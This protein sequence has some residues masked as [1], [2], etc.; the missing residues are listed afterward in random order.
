MLV[1]VLF[2]LL[3]IGLLVLFCLI[4][5]KKPQKTYLNNPEEFVTVEPVLSDLPKTA[6]KNTHWFTHTFM[7]PRKKG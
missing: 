2:Q 7:R 3:L 1:T 4:V 5:K 6:V